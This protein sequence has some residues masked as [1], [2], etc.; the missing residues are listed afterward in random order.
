M[1][2]A[3]HN[4]HNLTIVYE[5]WVTFY[6]KIVLRVTVH[7][8]KTVKDRNVIPTALEPNSEALQNAHI[9]ICKLDHSARKVGH[10]L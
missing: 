2:R 10:I 6:D 1:K 5:K 9:I 8:S 4:L 3:Y 7:I